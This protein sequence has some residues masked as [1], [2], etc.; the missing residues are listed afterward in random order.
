MCFKRIYFH[1]AK[2]STVEE[3]LRHCEAVKSE[4]SGGRGRLKVE[5]ALE[6][7][8][9]IFR[10]QHPAASRLQKGVRERIA[11]HEI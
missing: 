8:A 2:V 7:L 10:P 6:K 1:M 5:E 4:Q 9:F 3:T 11:S